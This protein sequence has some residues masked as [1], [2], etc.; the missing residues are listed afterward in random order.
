[1][2]F[3]LLNKSQY[4]SVIFKLSAFTVLSV[5]G[6][7]IF[8]YLLLPLAAAFYACI[9]AYEKKSKRVMSYVIPIVMFTVN[10]LISGFYSLEALA[11]VVVG[12]IIYFAAVKRISK[13]EAVFWVSLAVA[14]MMLLSAILLSFEL[15]GSVGAIPIKQFYSNLYR[16]FSDSFISR[17]TSLT[18]K[19]EG[20][21]FTFAFNIYEAEAMLAELIIL[22]IPIFVIASFTIAGLSFKCFSRI[23]NWLSGE[24]S[25][26]NEWSFKTSNL[27]AY[28]YILLAVLNLFVT[29][30]SGVVGF[31]LMILSMVFSVIFAY[32][33]IKYT[34]YFFLSRGRSSLFAKIVIVIAFVLLSSAAVTV[35]SYIGAVINIAVNKTQKK[36]ENK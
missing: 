27:I 13:G 3:L 11:Y 29:S 4:G 22:V 23:V 28:F 14:F 15:T 7:I 32:V 5:I 1:M 36:L 26:V 9:L 16:N 17:V 25:E 10:L 31:S 12:V 6:C 24:D 2:Q 21:I 35:F 34:Y 20:G 33:G 18:R 19:T 30:Y 8:G